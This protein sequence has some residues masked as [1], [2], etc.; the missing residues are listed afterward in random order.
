M[1]HISYGQTMFLNSLRRF[2]DE[3]VL[4]EVVEGEATSEVVEELAHAAAGARKKYCPDASPTVS[5]L[6]RFLY[7]TMHMFVNLQVLSDVSFEE[8]CVKAC[9]TA[10][11]ATDADGHA[12]VHLAGRIDR[13]MSGRDRSSLT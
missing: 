2:L 9:P 12:T 7:C 13:F 4:A 6:V 5:S 3:V 1:C 11:I 10:N 8:S